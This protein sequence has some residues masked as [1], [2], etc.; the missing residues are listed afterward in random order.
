MSKDFLTSI[1]TNIFSWTVILLFIP[2]FRL[3]FRLQKKTSSEKNDSQNPTI[4]WA[5]GAV[6]ILG[7]ALQYR[8]NPEKFLVNIY[9]QF[10]TNFQLNLA[11]RYMTLICGPRDQRKIATSPESIMSARTA[12]AELG[13]EQTLGK[14]NVSGESIDFL[15][16]AIKSVWHKDPSGQVQGWKRAIERAMEKEVAASNAEKLDFLHLNRRVLLRA[17]IEHMICPEMLD[18]S[19]WDDG[20]D[21]LH[22]YMNFQDMLEDVTAKAGVIHRCIALPIFLWPAQRRRLHLQKKIEQH[23]KL[24]ILHDTSAKT[25][26]WLHEMIKNKFNAPEIAEFTIALLFAAHKNPSIASS[27]AY[28]MLHERGTTGDQMACKEEAQKLLKDSNILLQSSVDSKLNKLC[29]EVLRLTAH[30]IGGVRKVEKA[31][32]LEG[33]SSTSKKVL[34][35]KGTTIA[36]AHIT[37]SLDS[38]FWKNPHTLDLNRSIELYQNEYIFTTFSHGIHKCPGQNIALVM[39]KLVTSILL[40]NYDVILP[41][42][43]P[44]V[45]FQRNTLAQRAYP[46]LVQIAKNIEFETNY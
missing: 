21:F 37:S 9:S 6:P 26:F 39:M 20:F 31:F 14:R 45:S 28:L 41:E 22:E 8:E 11:G 17:V 7:H 29:L 42:K 24:H 46:V 23:L 27:Q 34:I 43:V 33:R 12:V 2:I 32:F 10:G 19:K 38:K 13:F 15:K 3:F 35:P 36:C 4:P 30:S 25:G 40:V 1:S 16:K 18:K 5:P 44:S